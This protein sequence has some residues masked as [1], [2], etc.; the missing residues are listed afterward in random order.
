MPERGKMRRQDPTPPACPL[1]YPAL[2]GLVAQHPHMPERCKMRYQRP[3][4]VPFREHLTQV[5]NE[6]GPDGSGRRNCPFTRHKDSGAAASTALGGGP[7]CWILTL[8]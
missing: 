2:T 7:W 3:F 6:A 4:A 8:R 1:L 5:R